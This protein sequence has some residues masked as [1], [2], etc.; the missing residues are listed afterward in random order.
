MPS[1]L[2]AVWRDADAPAGE[3]IVDL[4]DARAR[5]AAAA[6]ASSSVS[7]GGAIEKSRRFVVRA[8][9]PGRPDE[10]PRDHARHVVRRDE[11]ARARSRT[12]RYSSSSG[13]TS[14]CAAT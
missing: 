6:S 14:S 13:T 9:A 12:P 3:Q 11:H 4:A 10:R 7:A 2:L 8:Y 5:N 1:A